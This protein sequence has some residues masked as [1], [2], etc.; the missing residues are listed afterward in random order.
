M[1]PP[2]RGVLDTTVFIA[3]ESGR[4][5][6][7]SCLP[8][9]SAISVITLAELNAGVLAAADVNTRALRMATLDALALMEVLPVDEPVTLMWAR[10]RVHLAESGRRVNVNDLWIAAT[11][12][13]HD[14]PVITQD[15]DFDPLDGVAGLTIIRV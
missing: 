4:P 6:D 8:D 9:E 2:E 7:D 15:H 11:A 14:L 10:M 5:L 1:T 3:S 13:S 12:A